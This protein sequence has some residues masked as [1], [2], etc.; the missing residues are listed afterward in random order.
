MPFVQWKPAFSVGDLAIDEQHR[1]LL[2]IINRLHQVMM[3]GAAVPLK[4]MVFLQHW[5]AKHILGTDLRYS[6]Y[7]AARRVA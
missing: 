7:L 2:D 3:A 4:M 1:G 5:L 6:S